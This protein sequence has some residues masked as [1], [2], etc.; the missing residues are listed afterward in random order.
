MGPKLIK[1]KRIAVVKYQMNVDALNHLISTRCGSVNAFC[2]QF[3]STNF[4]HIKSMITHG[5]VTLDVLLDICKI[6]KC[7][8]NELGVDLSN[9]IFSIIDVLDEYGLRMFFR[10]AL[11]KVD[12]AIVSD[13]VH[14]LDRSQIEA[15]VSYALDVIERKN[16]A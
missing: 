1:D 5:N 12:S 16:D 7:S 11:T 2:R 4:R 3:P 6:L 8:P 14:M 13:I 15:C 9:V 10:H